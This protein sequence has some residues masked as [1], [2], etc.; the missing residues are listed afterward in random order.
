VRELRAFGHDVAALMPE[1]VVLED[2]L[3]D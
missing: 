1:G 2:Y 3:K